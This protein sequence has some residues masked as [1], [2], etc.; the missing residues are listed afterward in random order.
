MKTKL[1]GLI[2]IALAVLAAAAADSF[3]VLVF[4]KTLLYRHASITNGTKA[5]EQLG[6]EN[7]FAVDATENSTA[8]T[9]TNLARYRVVV[10][11]STSGDVFNDEQQ[12]AF[13]SWLQNGGGFVA[14]HAGIAGKVATEGTWPWYSD[15][16]CTE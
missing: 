5:L 6:G 9:T 10:F 11:L 8:F 2:V 1:I 7:H 16:C 4:S 15:L 14:I 3:R 12:N 13:K